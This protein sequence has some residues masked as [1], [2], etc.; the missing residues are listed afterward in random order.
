MKEF[1]QEIK[2]LLN[3]AR[4][5]AYKATNTAMVETYWLVGK[6]IIEEEQ[7]VSERAQYGA[8]IIKT[9]SIELSASLARGFSETNIRNF[10]LFYLTFPAISK[11]Q[12]ALPTELKLPHFK[13]LN[14]VND[15]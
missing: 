1:V 13:P 12:Q 11:I 10:P 6:R 14:G 15:N 9:L 3:Q 2:Q 5:K 4:Q 7:H 8:E